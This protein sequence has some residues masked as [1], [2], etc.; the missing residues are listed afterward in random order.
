M[1]ADQLSPVQFGFKPHRLAIAM[2][3]CRAVLKFGISRLDSSLGGK[4]LLRR[5]KSAR[6]CAQYATSFVLL[7]DERR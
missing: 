1:R 6:W 7:S 4:R 3:T 5:L 2:D